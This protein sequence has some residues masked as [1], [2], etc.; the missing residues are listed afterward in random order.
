MIAKGRAA[1]HALERVIGIRGND[2]AAVK[3][4]GKGPEPLALAWPAKA[5]A[6]CDIEMRA[7]FDAHEE[8]A[9]HIEKPVRFGIEPQARMRA[10]V[11]VRFYAAV[12]VDDED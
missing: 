10:G 6:V 2:V 9:A 3:A 8:T 1:S 11:V 5:D 12:V 4:N 7:V